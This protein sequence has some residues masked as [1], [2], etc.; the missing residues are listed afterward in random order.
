M[1]TFDTLLMEAEEIML[2]IEPVDMIAYLTEASDT[3]SKKMDANQRKVGSALDKIKR[4]I[5]AVANAIKNFCRSF[6]SKVREIFASKETKAEFEEWTRLMKQHPEFKNKK[7]IFLDYIKYKK[8]VEEQVAK[9]D[10]VANTHGTTE[11][12]MKKAQEEFEEA[13]SEEPPTKEMTMGDV[14]DALKNNAME[15]LNQTGKNLMDRATTMVQD[16]SKLGVDLSADM[17]KDPHKT[18]RD[19]GYASISHKAFSSAYQQEAKVS[20]SWFKRGMKECRRNFQDLMKLIETTGAKDAVSKVEHSAAKDNLTAMLLKSKGI[21]GITASTM[22]IRD[23]DGKIVSGKRLKKA[24]DSYELRGGTK[25]VK[26]KGMK[27]INRTKKDIKNT[28]DSVKDAVNTVSTLL[29]D[30]RES[31]AI[32]PENIDHMDD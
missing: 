11:A 5:M 1:D 3:E 20:T 30:L 17:M 19:A 9:F 24:A 14:V 31:V 26:S 7:I 29:S 23:A 15:M 32:R 18:I 16:A 4:A 28:A 27:S 8:Y 13:M 12:D 21:G 22:N 6:V 2:S 25:Y 10:K